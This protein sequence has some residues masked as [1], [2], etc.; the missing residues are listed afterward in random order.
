MAAA[1]ATST[2]AGASRMNP[3]MEKTTAIT[4]PVM[5]EPRLRLKNFS[6]KCS[7]SVRSQL[8]RSLHARAVLLADGD[9]VAGGEQHVGDRLLAWQPLDLFAGALEV[10]HPAVLADLQEAARAQAEQRRG[11]ALVV[12]AHAVEVANC[13]RPQAR[14]RLV[15]R[16]SRP[17]TRVD[18]DEPPAPI[19]KGE[20]Q[21]EAEEP[22]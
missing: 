7:A 22:G 10:V 13:A 5:N 2:A 8:A 15:A 12:E 9:R 21:P 11:K 20:Q 3:R 16:E 17:G 4:T 14:R 19:K 6:P 1:R 18:A